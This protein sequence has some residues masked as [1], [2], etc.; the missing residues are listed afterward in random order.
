MKNQTTNSERERT[1]MKLIDRQGELLP[2]AEFFPSKMPLDFKS[3]EDVLNKPDGYGHFA[4]LG[5]RRY[6]Y[7]EVVQMLNTELKYLNSNFPKY[8]Y[9]SITDIPKFV[10]FLRSVKLHTEGE[11]KILGPTEKERRKSLVLLLS[12]IF[13]VERF[14]ADH[15]GLYLRLLEK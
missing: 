3:L 1:K 4:T 14:S 5:K 2:F 15:I 10:D 12:L 7:K 6:K 8:S 13:E 9:E 11:L